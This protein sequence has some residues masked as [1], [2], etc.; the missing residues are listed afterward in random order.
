[1]VFIIKNL[2]V[3]VVSIAPEL[4]NKVLKQQ[5]W[6]SHTRNVRLLKLCAPEQFLFIFINKA[7]LICFEPK[8]YL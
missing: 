3:N 2:V 8:Q 1:M 5:I 7:I 4:K 6:S